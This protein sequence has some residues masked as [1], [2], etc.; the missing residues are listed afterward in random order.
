[1]RE[2]NILI[3][4]QYLTALQKKD[5]SLAPFADQIEF[6]DSVAGKVKGAEN[7]KAFLTGFLSAIN[8]VKVIQ[9]ICEGDYVVT[10]WEID[11]VFGIIPIL[12]KFRVEDGKITEAIGYF[13]PTPI[14][15]G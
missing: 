8:D 11:S 13:D 12:E 15:G 3:V 9:H 6:E 1:M 14:I 5:L 2:E 10:H 4:E 7:A